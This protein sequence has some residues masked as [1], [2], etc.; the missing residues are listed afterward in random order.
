MDALF[1]EMMSVYDCRYVHDL[2][3]KYVHPI[4]THSAGFV[5][6]MMYST[7]TPAHERSRSLCMPLEF[8]FCLPTS[9]FA[10]I[11]IF[12]SVAVSVLH[13]LCAVPCRIRRDD[14]SRSVH[15]ARH[16]ASPVLIIR[17]K[18]TRS[19]DWHDHPFASSQTGIQPKHDDR[20]KKAT[21]LCTLLTALLTIA[22]AHAQQGA[23]SARGDRADSP[24]FSR[25]HRIDCAG[26]SQSA[27][28][29]HVGSAGSSLPLSMSPAML[30]TEGDSLVVEFT[31]E[32]EELVSIE[33]VAIGGGTTYRPVQ[34]RRYQAGDQTEMIDIGAL[35]AGTYLLRMS[36]PD[37]SSQQRITLG[38]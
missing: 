16:G 5:R 3:F 14:C 23:F 26:T 30:S 29:D 11:S 27:R 2:S 10:S 22:T 34:D 7:G 4:N 25:V 9:V 19:V 32:R 24:T 17:G 38:E 12:F 13:V 31:L 20:M 37:G 1:F 28:A 18:I 8:L 6:C 21:T 36:T 33:L 15:V 35:P